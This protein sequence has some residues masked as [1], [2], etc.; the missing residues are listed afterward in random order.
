MYIWIHFL[1]IIYPLERP[2]NNINLDDR[3]KYKSIKKYKYK[4]KKYKYKYKKN[5]TVFNLHKKS[6]SSWFV[7]KAFHHMI[8]FP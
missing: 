6:N 2:F 1:E 4:Y 3:L 7:Q 5:L 8:A